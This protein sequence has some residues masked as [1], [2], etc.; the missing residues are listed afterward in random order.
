MLKKVRKKLTFFCALVTAAILLVMTVSCLTISEHGT[1]NK[2]YADFQ[3]NTGSILTYIDSQSTLSHTWLVQMENRYHMIIDIRDGSLPLLYSDL[4]SHD[5]YAGVLAAVRE[6]AASEYN[7]KSGSTTRRFLVSQETFRIRDDKNN[8]YYAAAALL[9][10]GNGLL[11]IAIISPDNIIAGQI[12]R[13]RL[14]FGAGAFIALIIFTVCAWFF[15]GRML[16]PI[17]ENRRRQASFIASASHELRSPLTV[18]LS[19][20]SAA[21]SASGEEQIRFFDAIDS[22]G[23]RMSHL[24]N[25]MLT[26]ANSDNLTWSMT[27]A[28]TEPDTLLLETYEKYELPAKEKDLHLQ[29]SLPESAVPSCLFDKERIAQMLSI[30][31]ENA[32]AYTPAGGTVSLSLQMQPRY[33]AFIITD[34]GPGIPDAQKEKIFE[35]FYRADE[36][37]QDRDHF[38]LG[39]CIAKEIADLHKGKILVSDTPGGGAC[40]TVLLPWG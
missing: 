21:R 33:L 40:F 7:L 31:I 11:D 16:R 4:H 28:M 17:E 39:L 14:L 25:D 37:H 27:P 19:S 30:L 35:R 13:Q 23:L 26:L 32:F 24:I 20:L 9:P 10:K 22:E 38:G 5:E 2:S 18:I 15:I 1:K 36:S 12:A 34:N 8:G 29:V 6:T 3:N